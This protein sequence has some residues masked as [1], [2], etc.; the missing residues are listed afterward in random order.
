MTGVEAINLVQLIGACISITETVIEIGRAAQDA[1]GLP[2]KLKELFERLPAIN[3][4]LQAANERTKKDEVSE[5]SRNSIKPV[6]EQCQTSLEQIRGLFHKACPEDGDNYGKRFWKGS[7]T[8]FLGRDSKLQ[9]HM[10][11]VMD[12]L[13]ILELKGVFTIDGKLDDLAETVQVLAEQ[14]SVT[15]AHYGTGNQNINEGPGD[16]FNIGGGTHNTFTNNFGSHI[17]QG[18]PEPDLA[19]LCLQS[20]AFPN[21]EVRGDINEK[22]EHTCEWIFEHEHYQTWMAQGGLLWIKGRAGTGKSPLMEYV[23]EQSLHAQESSSDSRSYLPRMLVVSFFFNRRGDTLHQT[24]LGLFRSVLHQIL[25][26]DNELL[27]QFLEDS[28]FE[29]HHRTKGDSGSG[30]RWDWTESDLRELFRRYVKGVTQTRDLRLYVDALDEGGEQVARQLMALFKDCRGSNEHQLSICVSCRPYPQRINTYD[31]CVDIVEENREDITRFLEQYFSEWPDWDDQESLQKVEKEIISRAS[32]V[33]QW[34][35]LVVPR[36][37]ER[38]EEDLTTIL[39]SIADFPQELDDLYHEMLKPLRD[40]NNKDRRAALRLFRWITFARRPLTLAELRYAVAV[41]VDSKLAFVEGCKRSLYWCKD[42]ESMLKRVQRLSFGVVELVGDVVQFDHES[43]RDYMLARGISSLEAGQEGD[44]PVDVRGRSEAVLSRVC[45]RYLAANDVLEQ[46]ANTLRTLEQDNNAPFAHLHSRMK[47]LSSK[48]TDRDLV[49]SPYA[50][51]QCWYHASFA[52]TVDQSLEFILDIT[53]W[54]ML[55]MAYTW[56]MLGNRGLKE[57][58]TLQHLAAYHGLSRILEQMLS[59]IQ[60]LHSSEG[61]LPGSKRDLDPKDC[62]GRTPLWYAVEQGQEKIVRL[63]L[64]SGR[65][66]VNSRDFDQQT[67]LAIAVRS[68]HKKIVKLLL[69]DERIDVNTEDDLKQTPLVLAVQEDREGIV[70]L[71]LEDGR[72]SVNGRD[73]R[74]KTPLA[75]AVELG[76]DNVVGLLLEN[77]QVNVDSLDDRG[78]T[79][80]ATAVERGYETIVKLF[81]ESQRS[82]VNARINGVRTPLEIA[83][84]KRHEKIVKVLLRSRDVDLNARNCEQQ[85]ALWRAAFQGSV[86]IT[87]MLLDKDEVRIWM[88]DSLGW[89]PL[90]AAA[91]QGHAQI[92]RL[93]LERLLIDVNSKTYGNAD[94]TL[95]ELAAQRGR[96]SVIQCLLDTGR[97]DMLMQNFHRS[98]WLAAKKGHRAVVKLLLETKRVKTKQKMWTGGLTACYATALEIALTNG[99]GHI[100]ELIIDYRRQQTQEEE[101]TRFT[102]DEVEC[103]VNTPTTQSHQ[104]SESSQPLL[105]DQQLGISDRGRRSDDRDGWYDDVLLSDDRV[106]P[107]PSEDNLWYEIWLKRRKI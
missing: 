12:N 107:R 80:F 44:P 18:P 84:E 11:D 105:K 97:V 95:L 25:R 19:E 90:W 54:P 7:K 39:A 35:I 81:L 96:T 56:N 106:H 26:H 43:V 34:V 82:N 1:K 40:E 5:E 87:N 6:L 17:H 73:V 62:Y 38:R 10:N 31:Y 24:A 66:D 49:L 46:S 51:V 70:K 37:V 60:T 20:L 86:E 102:A 42:D 50:R 76:H 79:P 30:K 99:H 63:L 53:E 13:K 4:L 85:T 33:F 77:E 72:A 36:V 59:R 48:E 93:F 52:D 15:N 68:H 32:G 92:L 41:D 16:Q 78:M 88:R 61:L 2:P 9:R 104:R 64:D 71:F 57:D 55:R 3:D 28:G 22:V 23:R 21:M 98:L 83:V 74:Q 69:E 14:D 29:S 8:V 103:G 67:P 94:E 75:I 89:T 100:V 45:F 91:D 58:L 47:R 27:S 65:I 101:L